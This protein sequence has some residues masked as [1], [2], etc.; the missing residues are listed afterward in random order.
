MSDEQQAQ[1]GEA[2]APKRQGYQVVG[3]LATFTVPG[4]TGPVR[5]NLYKGA[6]VPDGTPQDEIDH[7]VSVGLV[8]PVDDPYQ[9]PVTGDG[10]ESP[11]VG[12][13]LAGVETDEIGR[14]TRTEPVDEEPRRAGRPSK[15]EKAE[16]V[17]A[18]VKAGMDRGEAEK[19]SVSD[20]RAALNK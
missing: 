20:L 11:G 4:P 14:P 17:D 1:A 5:S 13:L 9:T 18:A 15:A 6:W 3:S 12:T 2:Q 19:A 16:L 7:N 8:A 10:A